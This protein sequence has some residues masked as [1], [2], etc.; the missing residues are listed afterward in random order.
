MTFFDRSTQFS[1]GSTCP[2]GERGEMPQLLEVLVE[3]QLGREAAEQADMAEDPGSDDFHTFARTYQTPKVPAA[4][5]ISLYAQIRGAGPHP[6]AFWLTA[7]QEMGELA[8]VA[9]RVLSALTTSASVE[10]AF[11]AARRACGDRQMS[12][13]RGPSPPA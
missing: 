12:M 10:C 7:H 2:N 5:Q 9:V 3:E 11:S 13:T 8:Q 1:P 6:W 4:G